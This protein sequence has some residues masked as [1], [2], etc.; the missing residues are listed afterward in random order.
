MGKP[1]V[2]FE[3]VGKDGK[4]L[5]EFYGQLFD[6]KIDADN[7]MNYGIVEAAEGG[8]GGGV[9]PTPDGEGRVT[10]YV[11][12]EDLQA[13]LDKAQSLGGKTIMP[14]MDVPGG[15]AIAMLADPEGHVIGLLKEGS[16]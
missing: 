12:V 7:P 5:Q 16:M 8:I 11:Q 6:W 1:V 13:Y 14:P 2:H 4:K 9:G 15:P 3:V 10:F